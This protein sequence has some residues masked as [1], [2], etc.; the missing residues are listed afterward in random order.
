MQRDRPID[1]HATSE[2]PAAGASRPAAAALAGAA[3]GFALWLAS[4]LVTGHAEPWDGE[5]PFYLPVMLAGGAVAG[6]ALPRR[7]GAFF[8]GLW[9][10]QVL[11]IA[12]LPGHG[13]NWFPIGA[14]ST[15]VGAALA[16][17]T[18]LVASYVRA[19]A[20]RA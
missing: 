15:A 18:Y 3:L 9:L 8:L 7:A 19:R 1:P 11:A 16:L 20:A 13:S 2:R 12:L 4:P 6:G 10:G 17:P 5:F 14:V